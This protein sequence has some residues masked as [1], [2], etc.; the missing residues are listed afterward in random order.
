[1]A[2]YKVL[3]L[4]AR[5]FFKTGTSNWYD[6][7][8]LSA[9]A[10]LPLFKEAVERTILIEDDDSFLDSGYSGTEEFSQTLVEDFNFGWPGDDSEAHLL[11]AGTQIGRVFVSEIND[12]AGNH[13]LAVIPYPY[14][15]KETIDLHPKYSELSLGGKKSILIFPLNKKYFDDKGNQRSR[16]DEYIEIKDA[17]GNPTLSVFDKNANFRV[18]PKSRSDNTDNPLVNYN[19]E[20]VSVEPPAR[21]FAQG[22]LLQTPRGLRAVETLSKG[23]LILTHDNGVQPIIWIGHTP[24]D[25]DQLCRAPKSQPILIRKGAL[26][27]DLPDR[28]LT[29]SPQHRILVGSKIAKRLFDADEVLVAA[30][31][32]LELPG[33][34]TICPEDGI[35]YWHVLLPEHDLVLSHGT[36]TESLFLGPYTLQAMDSDTREELFA[37]LPDLAQPDYQPRPA[38][39]ALTG[40]EGRKLAERHAKNRKPLIVGSAHSR[41]RALVEETISAA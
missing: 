6:G 5:D 1:M 19:E 22:S 4:S 31:H 15:S 7:F 27:P 35:R 29:V 41:L 39:R 16:D 13:F 33:I 26:G 40:R 10:Y 18:V 21:C 30:K 25:H 28:D 11:P 9:K 32:L 12:E 34:E 36:W 23:D 38:R 17:S 37:A 20:L 24:L 8:S 3:V 14:A 2:I